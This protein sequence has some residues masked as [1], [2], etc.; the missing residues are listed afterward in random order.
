MLNKEFLN[1]LTI[2]YVEDEAAVREVVSR[3]LSK[4]CK[5]AYVA[6]DGLEGLSFMKKIKTI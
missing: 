2:L 4:L 1:K 5:N 6:E 3:P